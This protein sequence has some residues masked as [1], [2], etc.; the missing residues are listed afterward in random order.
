MAENMTFEL[1][2]PARKLASAEP[3]AVTI[4][5]MNG[6]FTAMADHAPFLTTLRPGYVTVRS[7]SSEERYFVTGGFAEL[8]DN[9]VSVLAEQAVPEADADSAWLDERIAE[10]EEELEAA[11]EER[12]QATRQRLDDFRGLRQS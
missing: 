5:G 10:A 11:P 2:S 12:K 1:V 3:D 6:D 7:G 4:P 9:T 8:S